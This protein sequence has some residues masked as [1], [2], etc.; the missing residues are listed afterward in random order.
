MPGRDW[1]RMAGADA[2]AGFPDGRLRLYGLI[3]D[4]VAQVRAPHPATRRLR[5]LGANAALLPFH[6]PAPHLA[7]VFASLRLLGNFDG[8]VITVPHKMP[9]AALLDTLSDRARLVGAVNLARREPDG[10]WHGDIMDGVGF[11]RGLAVTGFDP[12]GQVAFVIGGG[13][14]GSAVAV[15]LAR[16]G[17][18]LRIYDVMPD[19]AE[20][21]AA[22]LRAA[23]YDAQ[24]AARPDPAGAA[25]V[26]NATPL[27]MQ[28]GDPLPVDPALLTPDMLVAEVVMKPPVTAF[29]DAARQLGCRIQ[30][31]EQV[32]LQQLDA[33]V[34]FF[35]ETAP[36]LRHH[37][38]AR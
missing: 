21:L 36:D 32:M 29:L 31:G 4:P 22:K 34:Q 9:M 8:M 24:A 10:R 16:A 37:D 6:L 1:Q 26:V 13:G 27:G 3:G 30:L 38:E 5:D 11:C 35:A 20:A 23:G 15:E 12:A 19:R 14:A 17:A 28:P 18:N 2:V 33:M 7:Q 25:L